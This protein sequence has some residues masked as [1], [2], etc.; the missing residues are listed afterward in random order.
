MKN[1][2]IAGGSGMIGSKVIKKLKQNNINIVL[3]STNKKH[4]SLIDSYYWNPQNDIFPEIDLASFDVCFN[5]CGSGIVDKPFTPERKADL[6]ESRTLPINFL[7]QQFDHQNVRCKT[8]ISAS[9]TGIYPNISKE[10]LTEESAHG[11]W[12]ISQ[13]TEQWEAAA[14]G[15][16][17]V[18]DQVCIFRIGIVL[19]DTG[20]FAKKIV[21]PMKFFAGAVPGNGQQQV[22]WIQVDDLVNMLVYAAESHL[23][24]TFNAVAPQAD[25]M[26]NICELLAEKVK[27]PKL[28]PH[29]PPF[30]L[31]LIFGPER[32]LLLLS[33]QKV[34]AEKIT[35]QGFQFQ[36]T[37]SASAIQSLK[38]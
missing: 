13:L 11:N 15:M 21:Q 28:L 12:F 22:P 36:Y 33:D 9:A 31:R 3:L 18:S 7:K 2:L 14:N 5:F 34:S 8:F 32:H 29:L 38:L 10:T 35:G 20:G 37:T 19:S 1:V 24:G 23:D 4:N 16:R 25:T 30:L 17:T 26:Q 27:R 6:L